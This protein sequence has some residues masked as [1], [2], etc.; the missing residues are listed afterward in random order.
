MTTAKLVD[1]ERDH[2]LSGEIVLPQP[3]IADAGS[4]SHYI[5]DQGLEDAANAALALGQPLLLTGEPGTGKTRF[6][7]FLAWHLGLGEPFE[8]HTK[9][10]ST[11][12]DLFYTYDTV[13]RFHAAQTGGANA[14]ERDYIRYN[15]LGQAMLRSLPPERIAHLCS[16]REREALSGPARSVVLIDEIDKASRDFPNDLLNELS[17]MSFRIPELGTRVEADPA[18]RPILVITSN[19]E[20]PLPDPFLRRCVFYCIDSP[21]EERLTQI[22]TRRFGLD[23]GD[24]PAL[25]RSA[26]AFYLRAQRGTQRPPSVAELVGWVHLLLESGLRLNDTVAKAGSRA[27]GAIAK[28]APARSHLAELARAVS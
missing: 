15:A 4:P 8:F 19:Q 3:F 27:L 16:A 24:P 2:P 1:R 21:D 11:A 18:Y 20:R 22:L 9:S 6:A 13:R 23:G 12:T 5:L 25:V 26:A 10:T 17:A 28:T 14:D 7:H